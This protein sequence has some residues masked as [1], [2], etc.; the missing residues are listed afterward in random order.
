MMS[1]AWSA[2][3]LTRILFRSELKRPALADDPRLVL[4][5]FRKAGFPR[6]HVF[7]PCG[8]APAAAGR[9]Q[10]GPPP[11]APHQRTTGNRAMN[12]K[13]SDIPVEAP[14]TISRVAHGLVRDAFASSLDGEGPGRQQQ[15]FSD[16][17]HSKGRPGVLQRAGSGVVPKVT[18]APEKVALGS[19]GGRRRLPKR[20]RRAVPLFE[21][22]I[23][24]ARRCNFGRLLEAH[25][26]LPQSVRGTKAGKRRAG[27]GEQQLG[28]AGGRANGQK[29]MSLRVS[30]AAP[31]VDDSIQRQCPNIGRNNASAGSSL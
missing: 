25:C 11:A 27:E 8:Q 22:M 16:A 14:A 5:S 10:A 28:T 20:L 9:E 6:G 29:T 15:P 30:C 23:G 7:H 13:L 12:G 17:V 21:E 18:G 3:L 24:R 19:G 31:L 26:P 4:L 1:V 2:P